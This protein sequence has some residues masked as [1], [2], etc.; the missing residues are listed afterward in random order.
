MIVNHDTVVDATVLNAGF[1]PI[2]EISGGVESTDIANGA[3]GSGKLASNLISSL[4][5]E[6][7]TRNHLLLHETG[8]QFNRVT[9]SG[10][11]M[12]V[13]WYTFIE[14]GYER[15]EAGSGILADDTMIV[16]TAAGVRRV[17][18]DLFATADVS[19]PGTYKVGQL[20]LDS[21]GR[22]L[23]VPG[24]GH[25]VTQW[26]AIPPAGS[27]FTFDHDLTA[28]PALIQVWLRCVSANGDAG[29]EYNDVVPMDVWF[30][31]D[32]YLPALIVT[33]TPSQIK[34]SSSLTDSNTRMARKDGVTPSAPNRAKWQMR[35]YARL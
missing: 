7:P 19:T 33:A 6:T 4:N 5:D 1:S 12:T 11:A 9:L 17:R 25:W 14:S 3:V 22:V 13:P 8:G 26:G 34:I 31:N 16:R 18:A 28:Q 15:I 27:T 10:L 32:L 21:K 29:Y 30:S 2:A 20:A 23:S 24:A 35:I